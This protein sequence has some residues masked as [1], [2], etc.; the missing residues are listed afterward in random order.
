M[1]LIILKST[2]KSPYAIIRIKNPLGQICTISNGLGTVSTAAHI[3]NVRIACASA[4][5][6]V[7]GNLNGLFRRTLS[8]FFNEERIILSLN[9]PNGQIENLQKTVN[10]PY[11]FQSPIP[12][13]TSF[14]VTLG[15]PQSLGQ[16]CLFVANQ[17]T[18]IKA[19]IN[20]EN[21]LTANIRCIDL[22]TIRLSG[23]PSTQGQVD[24]PYQ[25]TPISNRPGLPFLIANKPN[26][27]TFNSN[28]GKLSGFPNSS[29]VFTGII[30]SSTDG[31]TVGRIGPFT[32][33]VQGDPLVANSW[34]L[35]N[36][37]QT[38]FAKNPGLAGNDLNVLPVIRSGLTGKGVRIMISDEGLEINHEDLRANVIA[39]AS[40]NY[41]FGFNGKEQTDPTNDSEI[42]DHGTSVAGIAAMRGWNGIGS[43]GIAPLASIAGKNFLQNQSTSNRLDQ[44]QGDFDIINQS[45]GANSSFYYPIDSAYLDILESGVKNLRGGKGII[46]VKAA[47]NNFFFNRNSAI[48]HINTTPYLILVGALNASGQ[49]SS[50]SSQ[51]ACLWIS[52]LGGEIGMDNTGLTRNFVDITRKPSIFSIASFPDIFPPAQL[53][54]PAILTTDSSTCDKGYSRNSLFR[55][56]L[57]VEGWFFGFDDYFNSLFNFNVTSLAAH[58]QNRSCNYTSTFNGT[59][60]AAPSISGV[61]ALILEANPS[62]TWREV[63][64]ILAST[65]TEIS[66]GAGWIHNSAGYHFNNLY[67][68]GRANAELAVNAARNYV[69]KMADYKETLGNSDEAW[70][71]DTGPISVNVP[72]NNSTGVSNSFNVTQNWKT[73]QIQISISI[74]HPNPS[75]LEITI[76]SPR[77]T[78]SIVL[79]K[80]SERPHF[81]NINMPNLTDVIFLSNAFYGE[82]SEGTWTVK[83]ADHTTGETGSV[84][85]V[86]LK[87]YGHE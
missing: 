21:Y 28:T 64:D 15:V 68:F 20:E 19:T 71:Y 31:R 77:G 32:I 29:G 54:F 26:W 40:K 84:A 69:S 48:D 34:H 5:F 39:E 36:T 65:S 38:T 12:N 63:K 56:L 50:Y 80:N 43:R 85:N 51:G 73:E 6:K 4:S 78:Q 23:T 81:I 67:G 9:L 8:H 59:S 86:K 24:R 30:I 27:A 22:P 11:Q 82:V 16:S 44:A 49:H 79:D 70:T 83:V 66:P 18:N 76:I 10:G 37:G 17:L 74:E 2:L 87:L 13:G 35:G 14:K 41:L 52:G 33:N 45:W 1:G 46:Y 75:N 61:I 42:G 72:D 60:A 47:G 3:T 55:N 58:P 53:A 57:F 62:L 25:F 7:G